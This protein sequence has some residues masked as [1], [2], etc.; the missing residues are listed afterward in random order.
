MAKNDPLQPP[1]V[2]RSIRD[3]VDL[4]CEDRRP[5]TYAPEARSWFPGWSP[6]AGLRA[7]ILALR[8]TGSQVASSF[9]RCWLNDG[10]AAHPSKRTPGDTAVLSFSGCHRRHVAS[11]AALL[12]SRST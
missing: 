12:V 6:S 11:F 8:I 1:T 3:K 10:E 9:S 2:H 7:L 4:R 5:L